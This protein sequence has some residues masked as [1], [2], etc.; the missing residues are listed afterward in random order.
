[1]SITIF[2][3][4][5]TGKII[6]MR[7]LLFANILTLAVFGY[8]V[9]HISKAYAGSDDIKEDYADLKDAKANLVFLERRLNERKTERAELDS[10]VSDDPTYNMPCDRCSVERGACGVSD[11]RA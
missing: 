3:I 8:G 2:Q 10:G 5:A 1:M 11:F 9:I 6:P 4:T 7:A